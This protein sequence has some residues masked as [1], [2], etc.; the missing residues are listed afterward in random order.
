MAK[1]GES[2]NLGKRRGKSLGT[3]VSGKCVLVWLHY[4]LVE[5]CS[6]KYSLCEE[7]VSIFCIFYV[8]KI[9]EISEFILSGKWQSWSPRTQNRK[10]TDHTWANV[11]HTLPSEP[12]ASITYKA[13]YSSFIS[14]MH[15][16]LRS[17]YSQ[18][19]A[20]VLITQRCVFKNRHCV[21]SI[22]TDTGRFKGIYIYLLLF[23][24][25]HIIPS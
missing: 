6:Y 3:V 9:L 7:V 13:L 11:T 21:A 4:P 25:Q 18:C 22:G 24:P 5:T 12:S 20:I 1:S 8:K 23:L 14:F 2:K 17:Q 16:E 10:M 15:D 19:S